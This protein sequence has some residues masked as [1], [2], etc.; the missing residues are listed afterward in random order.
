LA[1]AGVHHV[2]LRTNDYDGALAFYT[3]VLG[4]SVRLA[5][6]APD[7]RRLALLDVGGGSAI[8]LIGFGPDQPAPAPGQ[9][10]PWMHLALACDDP[11][12]LWQRAVDAGAPAVMDPRDVSLG[13]A[14]ARIAF[15][16]GPSGEVVELFREG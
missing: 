8:E 12:T 6:E 7:G 14:P 13:G 10:H 4:L 9:D 3:E 1:L 11:D 15:F 16:Q 5:W 2:A